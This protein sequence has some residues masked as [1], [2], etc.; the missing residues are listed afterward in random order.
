MA[1]LPPIEVVS[2]VIV[3][4][5]VIMLVLVFCVDEGNFTVASVFL[6]E[7]LASV[8]LVFYSG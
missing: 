6:S 5:M 8:V 1:E 3:M 2:T 4:S 7:M